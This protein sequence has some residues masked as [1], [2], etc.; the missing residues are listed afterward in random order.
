MVKDKKKEKERERGREREKEWQRC[1][2]YK[3]RRRWT[4]SLSER[5]NEAVAIDWIPHN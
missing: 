4:E 5:I 1:P 3:V 2:L